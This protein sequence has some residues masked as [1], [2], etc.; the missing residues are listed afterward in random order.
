MK[1]LASRALN[2]AEVRGATYADIRI[3]QRRTQDITVILRGYLG[4]IFSHA[5]VDMLLA[6]TPIAAEVGTLD[7]LM[8]IF[9][10]GVLETGQEL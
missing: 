2:L 1:A 5:L 7:K 9:L 8:D 10:H 3:V 4:L 6:E